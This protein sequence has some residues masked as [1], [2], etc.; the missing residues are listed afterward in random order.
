MTAPAKISVVIPCYNH[1]RYL[2]EAGDSVLAQSFQDFEI[3]IVNDGSTD[4]ET[5]ALL[6]DYRRPRVRVIHS[7]NRGL[8]AARNLGI[9]QSASP[10]VCA[11]D[12]DDLLEPAYFEKAVEVL[13]A[14]SSVT[15]VSHWL[16]TFGDQEWEWTPERC[17]LLSLLDMNTV[18][19]AALVRRE[20]VLAVGL[21][22]ETMREG[23]E[24]WDLWISLVERGYRGVILPEFLFRYRRRPDSMSRAMN[25]PVVQL[26]LFRRLIEKHTESYRFYLLD[27]LQRRETNLCDLRRE[28]YDLEQEYCD[29]WEPELKRRRAEVAALRHKVEKIEGS[30]ALRSFLRWL[31][32]L[33]APAE[34]RDRDEQSRRH[35]DGSPHEAPVGRDWRLAVDSGVEGQRRTRI[36][37]E[38]EI[39]ELRGSWSW[40]LT[41]PLRAVA[42]LFVGRKG[43]RPGG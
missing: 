4:P 20:A 36:D 21:F 23:C 16:R 37:L 1:G 22:D 39:A 10:Y 12:A 28:V 32:R 43:G 38:R 9:E 33:R 34:S 42:G 13:D 14:D 24:D 11:L 7:E 18:N 25:R 27:L 6:Q 41:A 19:G 5:V 29:W 3:L 2:D 35:P 8:P 30:S 26:G 15:F 40:R 31:G 17:D